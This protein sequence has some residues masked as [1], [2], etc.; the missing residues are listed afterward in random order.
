[1]PKIDFYVSGNVFIPDNIKTFKIGR[2]YSVKFEYFILVTYKL[3]NHYVS[4]Q[5]N[6]LYI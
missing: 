1:M 2:C 4:G 5:N 3:K 6:L